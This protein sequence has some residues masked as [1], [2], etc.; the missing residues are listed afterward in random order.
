MMTLCEKFHSAILPVDD[1]IHDPAS[2]ALVIDGGQLLQQSSTRKSEKPIKYY[3]SEFISR[4]IRSQLNHHSR[5]DIIFDT[6]NSKQLK[7]FIERHSSRSVQYIMNE[8]SILPTGEKY[9]KLLQSNRTV[10]AAVVRDS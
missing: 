8:D 7:R 3:A 4:F 2:S 6:A 10:I 1:Q 9:N 5:I